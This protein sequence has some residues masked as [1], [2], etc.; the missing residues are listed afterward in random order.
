[1][2]NMDSRLRRFNKIHHG[3]RAFILAGGPSLKDTDVTPL[4]NEITFGVS[5][6][7]LKEGFNP[8]YHVIG[9]EI[10]AKQ[11]ASELSNPKVGLY[12][13]F[14]SKGI[15]DMQIILRPRV[16]YFTGTMRKK[17]STDF[18]KP[19][20]GGWTSTYVAMQFCYYMGFDKVYVLGL[21]HS[22]SYDDTDVVG[23][24]KTSDGDLYPIRK[25]KSGDPNHFTDDYYH[26]DMEWGEP[27]VD[28]M[29][30][31]YLMAREAF[32][33]D[34]REIINV[35]L[36]TKLPLDILPKMDYNDVIA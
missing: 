18:T 34:G 15:Y 2:I 32:E 33:R 23:K 29:A 31:S 36:E 12:G 6:S 4:E 1:M 20:Y 11:R 8:S 16:Y 17:F 26:E 9:D 30:E 14:T 27:N 28:G 19:L 13:L 24:W 7:Y 25:N 3:E 5:L 22:W 35:S 10:I 21:D